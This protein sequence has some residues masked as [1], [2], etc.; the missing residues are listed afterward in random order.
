MSKGLLTF[1]RSVGGSKWISPS[2]KEAV[3]FSGN[4]ASPKPPKL[5]GAPL[6]PSPNSASLRDQFTLTLCYLLS[7]THQLGYFFTPGASTRVIT[8]YNQAATFL[9]TCQWPRNS[10]LSESAAH[11]VSLNCSMVI[12]SLGPWN[13]LSCV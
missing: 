2:Q 8:V 11:R 10:I 13:E 12:E 4:S 1:T 5:S 6:S 9:N 3:V 7:L